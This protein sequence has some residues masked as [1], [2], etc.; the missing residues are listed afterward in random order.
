VARRADISAE[1]ARERGVP[2]TSLQADGRSSFARL[3]SLVGAT[4]WA[5]TYLAL[6]LGIDPTPVDAI[7]SLKERIRV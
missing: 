7:T 6:R 1:L 5:S 2:V 4:D 3:A